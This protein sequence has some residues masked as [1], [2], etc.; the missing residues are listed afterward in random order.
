MI[1]SPA[2]SPK[3]KAG[4]YVGLIVVGCIMALYLAGYFFLYK[5]HN[6]DFPPYK[7]TP[8][9][10]ID[11]WTY[12]GHEAYTRKWLTI[13]LIGGV[14]PALGFVG[15][16]LMPVSR[17]LHGD[18]RFAKHQEVKEAGLLGEFGLILGKWGDRFIM[19]AGQ[20]GAIC[21]APPR[22]GKGAGLV[23]PNMLNWPGS[24]VLLDV[25]QESYRITAGFR[26]TFSETFLFNPVAEDGRTM[27]WNPLTYVRDDP[28]LRINDTQKIANMLSP[29]PPD[30]DPFWPASCRTLFLGL[31]LYLFETPGLPRT[32]GEIVRQIMYGEGETVGEHWKQIIE[33]RD[34]SGSP[35]SSACKAALYDFIY[36]SGNTQSSIRKTFTAK[37]ELWLNPLVDAATS[38]DSFDL[39][40]LR[41]RKISV[42]V[43]VRPGDL[44]RL[45][46]I[47]NLFFEQLLDLNTIEMPEDNPALKYELLMMMDEFTAVGRMPIFA[48]TISFMG[49]Y[50]IRPFI[51]VQGFSQLRSTYGADVAE[52]IVTC[53]GGLIAF[54]PK[55]QKH[56]NEI[57]EMLGDM[58]VKSKSTSR[59]MMSGKGGSVNTSQAPRRLLKPQEVKEIGKKREIIFIENVKPILCTK[60]SYWKDR[61]FKK[62][63]N[64]PLPHIEPIEIKLPTTNGTGHKKK[65]KPVPPPQPD[66]QGN[67]ITVT[68]REITP[69][70]VD[71]LDQLSLTDYNID[72][73]SVEVPKGEPISD[74]DMKKA[75]GSF[76][77]T[78]ADE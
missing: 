78:I 69:A 71:K 65:A 46:L 5:L 45:R 35:L 8:L 6:P 59:Q 32:F 4:A 11:Y 63:A 30:G 31:A 72:F 3:A 9:T 64:M 1:I 21:A 10:I 50:N 41:R 37:L 12:Y 53:C 67:I 43:G 19:L 17:A 24:V 26:S 57:S 7:A 38:G 54:A 2:D 73:E 68:E 48:K 36:T 20:L 18:A 34:A 75:F 76:L 66:A 40:D 62:R 77:Q 74:A 44:D 61:S 25:R 15:A 49:G 42:Y 51:I 13:C 39:R 16:L 14:V 70:D 52:T 60:I 27:Q 56:A 33:E 22:S 23:Q 55:E 28:V 29:D 47:L 58:T